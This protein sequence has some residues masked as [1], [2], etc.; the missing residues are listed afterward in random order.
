MPKAIIYCRVS[1]DRQVKEGHGLDGQEL[2]C[3]KFAEVH[4]YEVAAV[5]RDEGVSGGLIDREGMQALLDFLDTHG[6]KAEW[7]VLIDDIKRLARDLIGHFTLRKAIQSRGAKLESPSHKFGSEPEEVFV[8]SIM[9]ATAE[10]ERNQNKRQVRNRMQARLEAGYW[11]FYPPPGYTFA[12]VAGHG[13][14][15]VPK[16]PEA[17]IIREALEGFASGRFPTQV[18]V[19]RFL[20][21]KGF[22]PPRERGRPVTYLE[23]V[24]RLLTREVYTGCISYPP[25]NV[26]RRQGHHR[27]LIDPETFDRIQDRLKEREKLPRRKDLHKDFPLRGFVVCAECKKPLTASWCRGKTKEFA[28]YRCN[29]FGCALRNQCIRADRLHGQFEELLGKLKP[30]EGILAGFRTVLLSEWQ[31]RMLDVETVRKERQRKLDALEEEMQ[32]LLKA[33]DKCHSPLVIRRI[34]ERLDE[35]EAKKLRL[36][37]RIDKPAKGEY[38]FETALDLALGFLKNPLQM[39]QTGGLTQRRLVLRLAFQ[40]PLAYS[41]SGGFE[42]PTF[43]PPI[44]L[45]CVLELDKMEMVDMVRRSWNSLETQLREW[46]ESLKGLR[47]AA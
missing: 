46:A 7:V 2:R 16:E 32:G 35:L 4:G 39:W 11:P 13:K 12:K 8:E 1:S 31:R 44:N 42:T 6:G 47:Q 27:P 29:T 17:T 3:R 24:K 18:D 19:Q 37:G 22:K 33:I 15:L 38:D 21:A 34:E 36:G 20:Q 43:S 30:R 45:A 10:Y 5:F 14:L 9:A 23:Q 40:E 26:T 28:Y 25:W 41:R